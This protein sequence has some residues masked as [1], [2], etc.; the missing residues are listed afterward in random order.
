MDNKELAARFKLLAD[1]IELTGGNDFKAKAYQSA[2]FKLSKWPADIFALPEAEIDSIQG[3]GAGILTKIREIKQTGSIAELDALLEQVPA[4]VVEMLSIKGIGAKKVRLIWQELEIETVGELLYAC[5]ENRLA[6]LKGFGEKTQAEVVKSIEFRQ[7]NVGRLKYYKA[8]AIANTFL[9]AFSIALEGRRV[10]VTGEVRR[11]MEVV[12]VIEWIAEDSAEDIL[13]ALL[14]ATEGVMFVESDGDAITFKLNQAY[15]CKI[16]L[17]PIEEFT[18]R[19]WVTTGSAHHINLVGYTG[20][21]T[22]ETEEEIYESRGLNYIAPELREGRDEVELAAT[23]EVSEELLEYDDIKGMLHNHSTY[24]DGLHSLRDMA[25]YCKEQGWEYL[26]ICDHSQ[27]AVYAGGLKPERIIEQHAEIDKLNAE[28]APFKILKGI[29]SDILGD[30]SLDYTDEVLSSFDFVVASIHQG[31]K[32]SAEQATARL[33]KAIENPHTTILGHPTGRLLL[34]RPGYPVNHEAIIDAC[35]KHGVVIELNAN[36]NRLD[37]D[38]RWIKYATDKGVMISINPDA[39]AKEGYHDTYY[40][41]CAA[42][43]GYLKPNQT[44]NC[45]SLI[46]IEEYLAKRKQHVGTNV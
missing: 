21:E 27:T 14:S 40:G 8:E 10:E 46:E 29:E 35:A 16:H 23:I 24:S 41:V 12:D 38:W 43:K 31:F 32:M 3:I 44:F 6:K 33:I 37:M 34:S 28:L 39:H 36:P 42:R 13:V 17:A 45:F 26:G 2:A 1:L 30:G 4:G 11:K 20:E 15:N 22:I 7:A 19:W 25:V 9:D 18:Y 5:H